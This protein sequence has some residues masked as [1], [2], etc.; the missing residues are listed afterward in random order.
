MAFRQESQVV[1][2]TL[3]LKSAQAQAEEDGIPFSELD[4]RRLGSLDLS[5]QRIA[6]LDK[7]SFGGLSSLRVLNL[8]NNS[9]ESIKGLEA[10]SNTLETLDL[11]FN[12]LSSLGT[13]L[14]SLTKLNDLSLAS[15]RFTGT[16]LLGALDGQFQALQVLSLA[17]NPGIFL[18]ATLLYLNRFPALSALAVASTVASTSSTNATNRGSSNN[19]NALVNSA[20]GNKKDAGANR[21]NAVLPPATA[22]TR[23]MI[24][25]ALPRLNYLDWSLVQGAD[26]RVAEESHTRALGDLRLEMKKALEVNKEQAG[27]QGANDDLTLW[28]GRDESESKEEDEAG[29]TTA[30]AAGG[31]PARPSRSAKRQGEPAVGGSLSSLLSPSAD[32]SAPPVRPADRVQ[33]DE[34]T[35]EAGLQFIAALIAIIEDPR[36]LAEVSAMT[37]AAPASALA[38]APS[39]ATAVPTAGTGGSLISRP[40]ETPRGE[41]VAAAALNEALVR[42][43]PGGIND[44]LNFLRE[45]VDFNVDS[46]IMRGLAL[47]SEQQREVMAASGVLSS[48]LEADP[49]LGIFH[50][51][52]LEKKKAL[53]E[54]SLSAVS[55]RL[56]DDRD[57]E[58]RVL[59]SLSQEEEEEVSPAAS[60]FLASV[61]SRYRRARLHFSS[62]YRYCG[63]SQQPQADDVSGSSKAAAREEEE[64]KEKAAL[65]VLAHLL[66]RA[67]QVKKRLVDAELDLHDSAMTVLLELDAAWRDGEARRGELFLKLFRE[68]EKAILAVGEDCKAAGA[69]ACDHY[70]EHAALLL[71][72]FGNKAGAASSRDGGAVS[73]IKWGGEAAAPAPAPPASDADAV[74]P[75]VYDDELAA[76]L[77][78]K[79]S[80]LTAI[81]GAID[82]RLSRALAAEDRTK[83]IEKRRYADV[84][85]A[86]IAAE[87]ERHRSRIVEVESALREIE[88][89]LMAQVDNIIGEEEEDEEEEVVTGAAS[90][91]LGEQVA[92]TASKEAE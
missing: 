67:R 43:I 53:K 6:R 79:E 29:G 62:Y 74:V 66:E 21:P 42:R 52:T 44:K 92:A 48:Y 50:A 49:S 37:A 89:S 7:M 32:V 78:D 75:V 40:H 69:E 58:L 55:D 73:G 30:A 2:T 5:F 77:S 86:R 84:V 33:V 81:A 12:K 39:S 54:S 85:R 28:I 9:L 61:L 34:D 16:S 65:I 76:L 19:V 45:T 27:M 90:P 15:N 25:A 88:A 72:S 3:I 80:T 10:L 24:L 31:S 38:L 57:D 70:T 11:S 20:A 64:L 60:S 13:S 87:A 59:V 26:K 71:A 23:E 82:A 8:N 1:S 56:R 18:P 35:M 4:L 83:Q 91:G 51:F 22:V 17:N 36:A 46:S 63:S 41:A 14:H 68:T 47:H